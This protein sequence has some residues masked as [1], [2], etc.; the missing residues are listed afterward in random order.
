M[1]PE[2]PLLSTARKPAAVRSRLRDLVA[3]ARP[4]QWTKNAVCLAA[5]VFA[6]RLRDPHAVV[7]ALLTVAAFC[8]ASS[9]V[10]VFNDVRDRDEDRVHPRK[11]ERPVAA[12]R[13]GV[14][15]AL[16]EAAV[17]AASSLSVV[18]LLAPRV[19]VLLGG[20]LSLHLAY[21]LGLKRLPLLDVIAIALGF[22]LRV[23]AGIE[24]I[25]APQSAWI[26]LCM[27]F[28]ALFLGWGKRRAELGEVPGGT[29]R[30]HRRTL[31]AYSVG[32]LDVLL[33]LS[34][35]TAIVCYSLY[36]V[37]VQRDEAFLLTI[38]PVV[39]GIGRYLMLVMA[40][41]RSVDPDELLVGDAPLAVAIA[42]WAALSIA[43]L[44]GG[45]SLVP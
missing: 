29:A 10:Y 7:L 43:V 25:A 22:V 15:A 19:R 27:F 16:V 39:F 37:T 36:A 8:L 9:A 18:M 17:L 20:Y 34:A 2:A 35:G 1:D 24:A 28:A 32:L 41:A 44:Y 13:L 11:R 42:V 45:L 21:S 33:G 30:L 3:T 31:G 23:Q 26:V 4:W 14:P 12:G 38:L 40:Q 6:G 5:L